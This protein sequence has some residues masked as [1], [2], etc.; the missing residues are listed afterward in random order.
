MALWGAF[1]ILVVVF[2][3]ALAAGLIAGH[4]GEEYAVWGGA[5]PVIA[6]ALWL[7]TRFRP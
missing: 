5:V 4:M 6:A 7:A 3:G 1:L 2:G